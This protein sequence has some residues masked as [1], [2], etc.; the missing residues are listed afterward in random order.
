MFAFLTSN[1]GADVG[2]QA[3][4]FFRVEGVA[5]KL[6]RALPPVKKQGLKRILE[7]EGINEKYASTAFRVL[8]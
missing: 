1:A 2:L 5:L 3:L 7:E 4:A 6:L 8:C